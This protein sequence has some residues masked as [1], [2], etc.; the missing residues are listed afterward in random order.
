MD[1]KETSVSTWSSS[2]TQHQKRL[3]HCVQSNFSI[4]Q[5]ETAIMIDTFN[6][7]TIEAAKK[8]TKQTL[9]T[10]QAPKPDGYVLT[11]GA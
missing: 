1:S 6:K 7:A 10:G 5:N 3:R 11:H 8:K 9:A 4:L 2:E